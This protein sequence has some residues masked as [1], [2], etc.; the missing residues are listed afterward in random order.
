MFEYDGIKYCN[1]E[2]TQHVGSCKVD[3]E[4]TIYVDKKNNNS[5]VSIKVLVDMMFFIILFWSLIISLCCIWI[6]HGW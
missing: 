3:K 5:F 6:I 4:Y 2:K 1:A